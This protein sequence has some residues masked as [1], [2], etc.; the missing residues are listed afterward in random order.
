M[1]LKTLYKAPDELMANSVKDLLEQDGIPAMIRSF[2][3]PA[4]DGIARMMRP[5][6][7][8]VLVSETDLDRARELLES[9]LARGS[10]ACEDTDTGPDR[11]EGGCPGE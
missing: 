9:F 2:Q 7:G 5:N 3:V 1:S 6:W 4:Y 8:E 11:D 10:A